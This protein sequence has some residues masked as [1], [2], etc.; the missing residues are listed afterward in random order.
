MVPGVLY[1]QAAGALYKQGGSQHREQARLLG[2]MIS[3]SSR[4]PA[5]GDAEAL[6]N[7]ETHTGGLITS[8]HPTDMGLSVSLHPESFQVRVVTTQLCHCVSPTA[9]FRQVT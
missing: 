4:P 1:K 6:G 5:S 9:A 8:Q 2:T 3:P 7:L